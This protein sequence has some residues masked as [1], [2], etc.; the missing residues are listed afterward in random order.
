MANEFDTKH[1]NMV[2]IPFAKA[3]AVTN[4]SNTD[5]ALAG[6]NTIFVA[7]KAGSVVGLSVNAS[8]AL[9]AGTLS[10]RAHKDGTEFA[11]SG[12]PNP[13]LTSSAQESYASVRPRALTF[14]AGEGLG[15]SYTSSTTLDPTNT[16]DIDAIL[17]VVFDPD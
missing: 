9:T 5:I 17:Y 7:P 3:N 11:Q 6:G 4:Q 16:N 2:A 8:A 14:S 12:Y 10:V 13:E 15:V 1:G